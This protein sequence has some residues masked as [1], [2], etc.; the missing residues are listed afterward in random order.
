MTG[1]VVV[2][3]GV[4]LFAMAGRGPGFDVPAGASSFTPAP[5]AAVEKEVRQFA[6]SV[7]RDITQQ[8]PSAWEKHFADSPAFFM[9]SEGNLVFPNRQAATQA[10]RELTQTV[11]HMELTWGDDLRVD[12][13]TPE[14]AVLA[15]SWHEVQ[16]DK[17]GHQTTESGFFTGLAERRNGQ[18]QFR[19]A[20][21][22]VV[23]PAPVAK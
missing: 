8:G 19:N 10:I 7:S 5:K 14:F 1:W 6:A 12:A 11:Q 3:S 18:W 2:A 17:E 4:A 16:A 9:A 20:H 13:L 21:W 15:S 23:A 22:S